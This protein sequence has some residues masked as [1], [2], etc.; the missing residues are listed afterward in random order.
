[1]WVHSLVL[2]Q[3]L[4]LAQLSERSLPPPQELCEHDPPRL[5]LQTYRLTTWLCVVPMMLHVLF[6]PLL[7]PCC[8]VLSVRINSRSL[9]DAGD[10]VYIFNQL[11]N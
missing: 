6:V 8:Q 3:Q 11:T 2:V 10:L 7:S 1:M 9:T 5:K 4:A